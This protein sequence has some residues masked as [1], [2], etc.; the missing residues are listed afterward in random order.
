MGHHMPD[1]AEE[2]ES[3]E[4]AYWANEDEGQSSQCPVCHGRG[5]VN[6]LT[7]PKGF[8]CAG[9]TDC[10]MCDGDGDI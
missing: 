1:A 4:D 7:A 3:R 2:L 6:P 10:P 9:V 8:F 5:T